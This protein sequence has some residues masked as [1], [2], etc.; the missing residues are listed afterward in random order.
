MIN[1]GRFFT[2]E[3]IEHYISPSTKIELIGKKERGFNNICSLFEGNP[4]GL[5]FCSIKGDSALPLLEESKAGIILCW[6]DVNP[7]V[8]EN[9]TLL[10]IE[11]P[12]LWFIRCA[13]HFFPKKGQS[14]IHPSVIIGENCVIEDDVYI[15][16]YTVI[17]N[18]VIIQNG[19][20]I[21]S[22]VQVLDSVKIGK[23]V[24]IKSG[25][26]IGSEGFGFE[27]NE[28]GEY[29]RFP[30][31]SSVIIGNRVEI[32]A[33]TCIDRGTLSN[34]IIGDGTKIDNLVHIAHN[35][36]IGKNCVIVCLTCIAGSSRIG[37]GAWIAPQVVIRDGIQ[38]GRGAVVGMGA[39]VTKDVEPYD[40]VAGVPAK[41][42]K[43]KKSST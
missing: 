11:N 26:V 19:A 34:T 1:S 6:N 10:L 17:G 30:H 9:K 24:K 27:K 32:G 37:D 39:V 28:F 2:V 22:H 8:I 18:N 15:G 21:D 41:S 36:E 29:E 16:P 5:S 23:E 43:E 42:I 38:V 4:E 35:V 33:N 40:V 7:T 14:G 20:L 3:D 12:R 13:N 31:Y 25:C